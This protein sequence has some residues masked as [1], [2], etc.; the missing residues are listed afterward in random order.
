M[1]YPVDLLLVNAFLVILPRICAA[2]VPAAS[3]SG[4]PTNQYKDYRLYS[5]KM[6]ENYDLVRSASDESATNE[7]FANESTSNDP[8]DAVREQASNNLFYGLM[9]EL[10][11]HVPIDVWQLQLNYSIF[12]VAPDYYVQ[13]EDYL[14]NNSLSFDVL[15]ANIQ[16]RLNLEWQDV[17]TADEPMQM[18]NAN[19][20]LNAN[21]LPN[22]SFKLDTYHPLDEVS[23]HFFVVNLDDLQCF[24]SQINE[25]LRHLAKRYPDTVR[26]NSIGKTFENRDILAITVGSF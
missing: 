5:V 23:A 2:R 15:D 21:L 14:L 3:L 17:S 18:F 13:V 24:P 7:S 10:I 19:L 26:T 11:N 1:L 16:D 6:P 20:L 22:S 12:M 25:Y 9:N 8:P 4:L